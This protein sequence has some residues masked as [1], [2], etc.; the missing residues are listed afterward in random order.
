MQH[1]AILRRTGWTPAAEPTAA[2]ARSVRA[3]GRPA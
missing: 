3:A 1:H 2:G